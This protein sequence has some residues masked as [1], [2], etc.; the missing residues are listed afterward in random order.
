MHV[1]RCVKAA[2]DNSREEADCLRHFTRH[3]HHHA[4]ALEPTHHAGTLAE[5]WLAAEEGLLQSYR[6]STVL[7]SCGTSR[8]SATP[9]EI[10]DAYHG[11]SITH[12]FTH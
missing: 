8:N 2:G 11:S 3:C 1:L 9:A 12:L 4:L 7:L 10:A 5:G 6:I